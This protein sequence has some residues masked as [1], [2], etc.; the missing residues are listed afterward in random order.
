[1]TKTYENISIGDCTELT[2][3]VTED[4]INKFAEISGDKNPIH[5]DKNYAEK[6]F[7]KKRIAHGFFIGSLFSNLLGNKL[8]GNGTVYYSQ[9]LKFLAPVYINDTITAKIKVIEK[10]D[11]KKLILFETECL[12]QNGNVV[13][14]GEAL[15]SPPR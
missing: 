6:T 13:I 4:D 12:N 15:V 10:K 11:N 2:I 9:F 1:M 8:P 5:L 3:V 7:F 14:A